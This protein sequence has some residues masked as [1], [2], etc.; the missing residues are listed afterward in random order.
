MYIVRLLALLD[1]TLIEDGFTASKLKNKNVPDLSLMKL[2][3][4]VVAYDVTRFGSAG[5]VSV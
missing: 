2:S 1:K 3:P 5:D 4:H